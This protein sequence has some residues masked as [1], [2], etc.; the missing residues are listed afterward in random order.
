MAFNGQIGRKEGVR[1]FGCTFHDKI[2]LT[3]H[4]LLPRVVAQYVYGSKLP[5]QITFRRSNH[6]HAFRV[7]YIR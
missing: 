7:I 5:Q 1:Y 4:L 6:R 2:P 3:F